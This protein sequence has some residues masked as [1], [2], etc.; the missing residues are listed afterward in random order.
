MDA[1]KTLMHDGIASVAPPPNGTA[2]HHFCF[3]LSLSSLFL[4]F[5]VPN[6]PSSKLI[7]KLIE[8]TPRNSANTHGISL[9]KSQHPSIQLANARAHMRALYLHIVCISFAYHS[10][11]WSVLCYR[12]GRGAK[13][14]SDDVV[15]N[16][17]VDEDEEGDFEEQVEDASPRRS[18]SSLTERIQRAH[19]VRSLMRAVHVAAMRVNPTDPDAFLAQLSP[20]VRGQAEPLLDEV[21]DRSVQTDQRSLTTTDQLDTVASATTTRLTQMQREMIDLQSHVKVTEIMTYLM[22]PIAIVLVMLFT[23]K[24]WPAIFSSTPPDVAQ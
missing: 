16:D 18:E 4:L 5:S 8:Q 13:N 10:Q 20:R 14:R 19:S 22:T 15:D 12:R 3:L 17:D 7:N 23:S 2:T 11:N 1:I 24:L 9:S 21:C 6:L